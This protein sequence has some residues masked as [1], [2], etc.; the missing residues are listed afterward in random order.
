MK[1]GIGA[2]RSYPSAL[3]KVPE[4]ASRLQACDLQQ[5]GAERVAATVITLPTHPYV[6]ADI[7]RRIRAILDSD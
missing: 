6:P 4:V 2:T 7:G 5:P 3:N 1:N